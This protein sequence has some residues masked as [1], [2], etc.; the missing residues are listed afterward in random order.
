MT[1]PPPI[2]RIGVYSLNKAPH[3][4]QFVDLYGRWFC[5]CGME[6][7]GRI[8]SMLLFLDSMPSGAA[9]IIALNTFNG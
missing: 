8:L 3:V 4:H 1:D 9:A 5:P 6:A 2:L 7:T